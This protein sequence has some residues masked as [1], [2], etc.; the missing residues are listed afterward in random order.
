MLRSAHLLPFRHRAAW[1][2]ACGL[3]A[4]VMQA[5]GA[6]G[7]VRHDSAAGGF[8]AEICTSKGL[9]KM[10]PARQ[11]GSTSLPDS[12]H[13]DC[14]KLCAASASLL[15]VDAVLAVPPAPTVTKLFPA[16]RSIPPTALAWVSHPPRGPPLV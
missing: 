5:F 1:L 13:Q 8:Y 2:L 16:S 7:L 4:M 11:P 10:D 6:T 9:S 3:F 15:A 14:C 12:A